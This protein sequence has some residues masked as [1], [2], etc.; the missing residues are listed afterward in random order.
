MALNNIRMLVVVGICIMIMT[1]CRLPVVD[2]WSCELQLTGLTNATTGS[3]GL[4]GARMKC[5]PETAQ[6]VKSEL[7]VFVDNSILPFRGNFDGKLLRNLYAPVVGQAWLFVCAPG[8][9]SLCSADH[10]D[11]MH[12]YSYLRRLE[13]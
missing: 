10:L 4:S 7:T 3:S 6:E 11:A 2:C 8:R 5:S 13:M 9:K 1:G 12:R